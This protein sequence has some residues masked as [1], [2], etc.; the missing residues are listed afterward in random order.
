VG[1]TYQLGTE[2][3]KGGLRQGRFPAMDAE[4]G[5]GAGAAHEPARPGKEGD[6]LGRSG[7]TR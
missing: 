6:S 4:T 5:W 3:G 7:S 2:R 1:P